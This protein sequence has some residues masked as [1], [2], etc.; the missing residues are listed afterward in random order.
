[1]TILFNPERRQS[2]RLRASSES[3][4]E[5]DP[6]MGIGKP[7]GMSAKKLKELVGILHNLLAVS[8]QNLILIVIFTLML[9]PPLLIVLSCFCKRWE[10]ICVAYLLTRWLRANWVE[11]RWKNSQGQLRMMSS[12]CSL[13]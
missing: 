1:M 8:I 5:Q 9:N 6:R 13:C 2:A 7:R 11:T 3:Y 10:L 12:K 4:L